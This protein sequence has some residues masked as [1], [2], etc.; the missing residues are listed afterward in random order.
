SEFL[1][2]MSHE[3]RTPLNSLLIL[4]DQL[5][6]NPEGN[7]SQKQIEFSRTIHSSGNELLMLINDILDLSKIESGTVAMDFAEH[8]LADLT[9]YVERT[10]RHVAE[11]RSVEFAIHVGK[12]LPPSI[13]SDIKRLQQILKN[14]LSN[15]F[16]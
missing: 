10:F 11:A 13:R 2:N 3:L 14:L 1:A 9:S 5:C 15:A 8:R 4:S 7:L 12:R 16:K 6:K